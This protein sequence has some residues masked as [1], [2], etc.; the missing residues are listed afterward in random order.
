MTLIL[1]TSRLSLGRR[2]ALGFRRGH[3]L[4]LRIDRDLHPALAAAGEHD[5]AVLEREE[6][7]VLA[8]SD[9]EPRSDRGSTLAD[10]DVSGADPLSAEPLH[11]Q[12]L[13]CRI[14]AVLRAGYTFL[15]RHAFLVFPRA[16]G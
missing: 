3:G 7:V 2:P 9:V 5:H 8:A 4:R 16:A 12:P 11:T 13:R 1:G 14:A 6:R 15:M 10:D